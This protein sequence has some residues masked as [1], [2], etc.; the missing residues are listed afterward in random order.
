MTDPVP[1]KHKRSNAKTIGIVIG[2]IIGGLVATFVI[3]FLV[4]NV[5]QVGTS[6]SIPS[7]IVVS[8]TAITAGVGTHPVA[9]LFTNQVSDRLVS[10]D[11]SGDGSYRVELANGSLE[12]RVQIVWE[13][14]A[15]SNGVCDASPLRFN[16]EMQTMQSHNFQC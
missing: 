8:G 9:I 12:Y 3:F 1:A 16:N 10:G 14:L 7:T 6:P 4:V 15:S 13:G 11:V 2:A 5:Y